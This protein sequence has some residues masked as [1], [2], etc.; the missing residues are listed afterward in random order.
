[1]KTSYLIIGFA[2][3]AFHSA[4][5]YA[6]ESSTAVGAVPAEKGVYKLRPGDQVSVKVFQ[7]PKLGVKE[8]TID[9]KGALRIGGVSDPLPVAGLSVAEVSAAIL[10]RYKKSG[11]A[12]PRVT[13]MVVKYAPW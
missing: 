4:P 1:M 2:A 8:G 11:V 6:A 12:S 7:E 10:S 13:V 3:L 9:A 5:I